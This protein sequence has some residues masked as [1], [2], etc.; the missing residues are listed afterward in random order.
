[1]AAGKPWCERHARL[2]ALGKSLRGKTPFARR[3]R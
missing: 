2:F 1:V 3:L